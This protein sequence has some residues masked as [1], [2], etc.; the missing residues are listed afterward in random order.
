MPEEYLLL[1][2]I[3]AQLDLLLEVNPQYDLVKA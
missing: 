2:V 1:E 3:Q